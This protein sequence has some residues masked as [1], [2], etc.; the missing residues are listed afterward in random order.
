VPRTAMHSIAGV[1]QRRVRLG[2]VN[3]VNT[4]IVEHNA[5]QR[6]SVEEHNT[7]QRV[8]YSQLLSNGRFYFVLELMN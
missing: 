5:T 4:S 7:T 8:L 1:M 3:S 2:I 6:A